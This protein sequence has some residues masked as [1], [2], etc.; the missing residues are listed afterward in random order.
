LSSGG[1]W[2]GKQVIHLTDV[3]RSVFLQILRHLYVGG[4]LID[5]DAIDKEA[6]KQD[7]EIANAKDDLPQA[8]ASA[9]GASGLVKPDGFSLS[10]S[11]SSNCVAISIGC[12]VC[13]W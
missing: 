3:K 10:L 13:I 6:A 9:S 7:K 8:S 5:F 2:H 4:F 1:V 11:I 12:G